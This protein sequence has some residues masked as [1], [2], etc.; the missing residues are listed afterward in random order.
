MAATAL[1]LPVTALR[2]EAESC[3]Y[4]GKSTMPRRVPG[5]PL[6]CNG[7]VRLPFV[8]AVLVGT[9]VSCKHGGPPEDM[10]PPEDTASVP[11]MHFVVYTVFLFSHIHCVS[12]K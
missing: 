9:G 7:L 1:L 4:V 8:R 5:T 10:G 3:F 6:C 11:L 12:A 2:C